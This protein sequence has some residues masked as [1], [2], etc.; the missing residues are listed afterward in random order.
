MKQGLA[1]QRAPKAEGATRRPSVNGV[2]GVDSRLDV[3]AGELPPNDRIVKKL[4]EL[5]E[6][7]E[8]SDDATNQFKLRGTR[9]AVNKLKLLGRDLTDDDV[10]ESALRRILGSKFKVGSNKET[11]KKI[12]EIHESGD[13]DRLRTYRADPRR[14]AI[15]ELSKVWGIGY[16]KAQTLIDKHNIWSVKELKEEVETGARINA[17]LLHAIDAPARLTA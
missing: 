4:E 10:E 7:Y 1:C 9:R 8:S 3:P 6:F 14:C 13:L 12:Q 15:M 16:K 11:I 5:C 17:A 2:E